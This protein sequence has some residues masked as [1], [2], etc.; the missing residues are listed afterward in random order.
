L[1]AAAEP[2]SAAEFDDIVAGRVS[3]D[4]GDPASFST[5]AVGRIRIG[6]SLRTRSALPYNIIIGRDDNGDTVSSDRPIATTRNSGRSYALA[7]VGARVAKGRDSAGPS[8]RRR[9]GESNSRVA[10]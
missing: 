1:P 10:F 7:E 5:P 9:R 8:R 6:I 4:V 3:L 2:H